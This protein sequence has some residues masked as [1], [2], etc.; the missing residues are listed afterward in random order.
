MPA[1][2][3]AT[4]EHLFETPRPEL[5]HEISGIEPEPSLIHVRLDEHGLRSIQRLALADVGGGILAALWPAELAPQARY[6]YGGHRGGAL[7]QAARGEGW[8]V[9]ASPHLAFFTAPPRQRLYL[10]PQV[11][12]DEY[13]HRWE[14]PDAGWIGQY[15]AAEVRQELWPWLKERRYAAAT[16]DEALQDF[17]AILGRRPAHLRP[18]LRL[19]R[20]WDAEA[21][22]ALDKQ[23]L[24]VSIRQAVNRVLTAADDFR[25]PASPSA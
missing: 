3:G 18:G 16:D 9:E 10:D 23:Q 1:R 19:H 14:G 4:D 7:V 6:L 24:V 13:V 17:L 20:R 12:V 5:L 2:L 21:V 22:R 8:T 25:L 11:D 15:T